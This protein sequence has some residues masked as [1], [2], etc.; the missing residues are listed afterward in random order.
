M[1]KLQDYKIVIP[2][3][4]AGLNK[5]NWSMIKQLIYYDFQNSNIKLLICYKTINDITNN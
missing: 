2:T 3:I 4:A 5:R 1:N